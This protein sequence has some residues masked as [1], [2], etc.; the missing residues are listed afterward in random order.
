VK[1]NVRI[2]AATNKDLQQAVKDGLF[3]S[4]LFY[5]LNVV[6]LTL[7]PLRERK[8]EIP[9]LA[10]LFLKKYCHDAKKP[11]MR[12]STQAVNVLRAYPWPGNVRELQNAIERAVVL[13]SG[14]IITPEDFALQ[15]MDLS[16]DSPDGYGLPFHESV[17]H[18]KLQIIKRALA[19]AGGSQTGA[20]DLLGLQRTYLSRLLK[21]MDMKEEPPKP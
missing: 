8:E 3:R 14:E 10:E 17:E 15:P 7:P 16:K 9:Q 18:H 11:M 1:V 12:L 5:R 2:I 4:D 19:Q 6:S 13:K 20:A 21:Q